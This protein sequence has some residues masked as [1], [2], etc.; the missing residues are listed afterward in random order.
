MKKFLWA[1]SR[2]AIFSAGLLFGIQVPNFID[3]Y[4]K[5]VDA[6]F[7]EVSE[8]IIGFQSTANELFGGDLLALITY[9]EQSNDQV[10]RRDA[11]SVRII[12]DRYSRISAEH[13]VMKS[14]PLIV[15]THLVF[16][17]DQELLDE[18]MNQYTYTVP[19]NTV[20]IQWGLAIAVLLTLVMDFMFHGC[21]KWT[22]L[23][24]RRN[25]SI[26]ST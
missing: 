11:V 7:Q 17:A 1:Y 22:G 13:L 23:M 6:H 10:F 16:S 2:L 19:L 4:Q 3:Q 15:A 20:A 14:N 24:R 26:K 18:V 21:V 8:N 12:Y 9:Y 25:I 5:R